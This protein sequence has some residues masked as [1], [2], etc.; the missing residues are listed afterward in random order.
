MKKHMLVIWSY[1]WKI[2]CHQASGLWGVL[3]TF[4]MVEMDLQELQGIHKVTKEY[5]RPLG[6]LVK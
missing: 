6:K 3:L 4:I 2:W 5:T 1:L